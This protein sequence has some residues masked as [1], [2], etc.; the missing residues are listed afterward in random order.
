MATAYNT[1]YPNNNWFIPVVLLVTTWATWAFSSIISNIFGGWRRYSHA[2]APGYGAGGVAA[3]AAGAT[4]NWYRGTSYITNGL[5]TLLWL[6]LI[7]VLLN[8]VLGFSN[9]ARNLIIS[10]FAIGMFWA[11]MRGLGHIFNFLHR[12][13]DFLLFAI[14]PL[15]IAA[16]VLAIR[17]H[18][19]DD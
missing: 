12:I 10:V 5:Q 7:P 9:H 18:R 14:V 3:P 13:V 15:A 2:A 8:V 6:M 19:L 11:L 1:V 16:A 17:N 4:D